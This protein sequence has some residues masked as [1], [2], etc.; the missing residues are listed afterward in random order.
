M[1]SLSIL[2][3]YNVTDIPLRK[4]CLLKA[5]SEMLMVMYEN[6]VYIVGLGCILILNWI[7]N[8]ITCLLNNEEVEKAHFRCL[9]PQSCSF[10]H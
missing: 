10:G 4:I 8:C 9:Y 1:Y 3:Q 5:A 2:R 6:T 7:E